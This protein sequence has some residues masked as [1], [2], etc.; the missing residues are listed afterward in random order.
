[1]SETLRPLVVSPG[2]IS[3]RALCVRLCN[4]FSPVSYLTLPN[5]RPSVRETSGKSTGG[6]RYDKCYLIDF[7]PSSIF[8]N[9]ILFLPFPFVRFVRSQGLRV[10]SIEEHRMNC[11]MPAMVALPSAVTTLR[12][13]LSARGERKIEMFTFFVMN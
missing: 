4:T 13:K 8:V 1:M 3:C 6:R 11:C 10:R 12:F 7:A 9:T 5:P 2:G